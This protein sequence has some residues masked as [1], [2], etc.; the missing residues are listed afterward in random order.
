MAAADRE[1]LGDD[2]TTSGWF[3]FEVDGVEIGTFRS[4]KGL[5]LTVDVHEYAEGGQGQ[6]VH[7]LPGT[8]HWPNLVFSRGMVESDALFTWVSNSAGENFAANG[9][10]VKRSTGAVTAV[11]YTGERLRAWEFTDVFAVRWTGPEFNVDSAEL[12]V[13]ELEVA[14]NG[15]RA[16]TS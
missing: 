12:L 3:I 1:P 13:E 9:N 16:K 5:E 6:Y 11:S 10:K 14:H 8:L 2:P 7:K 4:V 15:F